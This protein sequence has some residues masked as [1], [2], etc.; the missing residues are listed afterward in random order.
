MQTARVGIES[1]L[2][3]MELRADDARHHTV[4][5]ALD[6][7]TDPERQDQQ[8]DDNNTQCPQRDLARQFQR[9]LDRL[10]HFISS[11]VIF[12]R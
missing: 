5:H 11:T 6:D 4:R 7:R 3:Q 10:V 8:Q 12:V 1:E 9:L 2:A